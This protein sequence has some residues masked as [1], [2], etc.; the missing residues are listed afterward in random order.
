[1]F[2]KC[3]FYTDKILQQ[4]GLFS[5]EAFD[6]AMG[7]G[8]A[9]DKSINVA[10]Q[11]KIKQL[12][13]DGRIGNSLAYQSALN[14]FER[15]AG[16]NILFTKV[17]V[18]WLKKYE[19]HQIETNHSPTTIGI[20][21]RC[22]RAIINEAIRNGDLPSDFYPFGRGK[23]E[24]PSAVGRKLALSFNDVQRVINFDCK[25]NENMECYRDLWT[26]SYLCNGANFNDILR[27]RHE[28]IVG[29]EIYFVRGKTETTSKK[30]KEVVVY[31]HPKLK[32]L[33]EKWGTV[34]DR[35]DPHK[36]IFPYLNGDESPAKAKAIISDV[37][38][39]T[40]K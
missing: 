32:E 20:Y 40:N 11:T 9:I 16:T 38:K 27:L 12:A 15:F 33:I 2:D 18:D 36:Y 22:L 24:I 3:V 1:M 6:K 25:G 17:T 26:F 34:F 4:K 8:N 10:F 21:L 28:N 37:I 19:R 39:R 13:I 7:I 23:Y 31:L 14:S 35:N 30:I 29:E 5:L